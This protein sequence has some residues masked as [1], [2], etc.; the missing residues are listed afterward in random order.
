MTSEIRAEKPPQDHIDLQDWL[1]LIGWVSTGGEA[2]MRIQGG[3]VY[4][5]GELETRRRRKLRQGDRVRIEDTE[6]EVCFE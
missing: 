6:E 2:K 4:V 3:E 1:K 5:N